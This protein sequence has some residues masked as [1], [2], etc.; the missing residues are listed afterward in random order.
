MR[1]RGLF[2]R[3]HSGGRR[4]FERQAGSIGIGAREGLVLVQSVSHLD[5]LVVDRTGR[6]LLTLGDSRGAHRAP[7]RH[8]CECRQVIHKG[9]TLHL[10]LLAHS[11]L[12][13]FS[14][15]AWSFP[16]TILW[17]SANVNVFTS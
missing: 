4:F 6:E 10:T 14:N 11:L 7:N 1:R 9:R 12:F 17:P 15:S 8:R 16:I 2:C 13:A 3:L 5:L